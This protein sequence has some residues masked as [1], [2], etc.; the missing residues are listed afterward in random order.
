M[1]CLK[2]LKEC[3]YF[4]GKVA[5]YSLTPVAGVVYRYGYAASGSDVDWI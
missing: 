1:T 4:L 3:E 5:R 2:E